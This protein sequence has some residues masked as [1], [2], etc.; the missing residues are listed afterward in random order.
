MNGIVERVARVNAIIAEISAAS[1]EQSSGIEQ[2]NVAVMQIG[3]ATP[4]RGA[5][6]RGGAFGRRSARS[7]RAARAGG[8][9][10]QAREF[11]DARRK[12][13]G[14]VTVAG[15][16]VRAAPFCLVRAAYRVASAATPS[17]GSSRIHLA[18]FRVIAAISRAHDRAGGGGIEET[19]LQEFLADVQRQTTWP[20]ASQLSI[21]SPARFFSRTTCS[22][23]H[24][25]RRRRFGHVRHV[26]AAP[27]RLREARE[28]EFVDVV[29][30]RA[31]RG[32]GSSVPR[33][34]RLVMLQTNSA[35]SPR[36]CG[37]CPSAS[38][39]KPDDVR[40]RS[41]TRR[42]SWARGSRGHRRRGSKSSRSRAAP[43]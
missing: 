23:R 39:R 38:P 18:E 26:H 32:S 17:D 10:V 41:R 12:A 29:R 22:S 28:V 31:P 37:C 4:E 34:G 20:S 30:N 13:R 36:C 19:V 43:R 6:R 27:G 16:T 15:G 2:V 25:Q 21:G 3:E 40:G 24:L 35:R 7:G 11:G 14:E 42:R 33:A 9:R 8:E 1:R 5:R